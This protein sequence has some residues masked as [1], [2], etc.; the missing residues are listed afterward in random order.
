[1]WN[2]FGWKM[3]SGKNERIFGQKVRLYTWYFG[4]K[5]PIFMW[6]EFGWKMKSG[7]NERILAKK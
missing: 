3:K 1:M 5:S 2:E 6:N 7:K 4:Q